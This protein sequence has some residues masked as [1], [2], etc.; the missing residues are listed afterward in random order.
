MS[1]GVID[2]PFDIEKNLPKGFVRR[3]YYTQQDIEQH[4]QSN[5]LWVKLFGKVL[6][7]TRLVQEN[8]ESPLVKPLI[9]FAGKDVSHW[10]N[11]ETKE[12]K[13]RINTQTG[14]RVYYCPDGRFLHIPSVYPSNEAEPESQTPWW[15]DEQYVVGLATEKSVKLKVINMLTHQSDI[16]EVPSE[17]SIN[18]IL[19][20]YKVI[21]DHAGSYIWK[22]LENKPLD[23][24]GTLEENGI[25]DEQE[26]YEKLDIPET[27]WYITPILIYFNDDLTEG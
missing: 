21:N 10:F 16:I 7:L 4:E 8:F 24:E 15:R 25:I 9:E 13:T 18:E 12:P 26:K 22:S 2:K 1:S 11:P 23:M 5:D 17:E 6:D 20:R 27:Q 14:F 3:R 19:N